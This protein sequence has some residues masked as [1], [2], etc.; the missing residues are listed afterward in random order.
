MAESVTV[1]AVKVEVKPAW[2]SK[3][4][5]TLI[6]MGVSTVLNQLGILDTPIVV[7]D[8]TNLMQSIITVVGGVVLWYFNTFRNG[9]VNP[10]S[11]TERQ[12]DTATTMKVEK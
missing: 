4:L 7:E 6:L 8:E 1:P 5:W 2:Q 10:A 9:T 12:I 3:R 11:L